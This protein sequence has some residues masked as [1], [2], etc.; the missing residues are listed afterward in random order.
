MAHYYPSQHPFIRKPITTSILNSLLTAL[1]STQ[2]WCKHDC[3]MFRAALCLAF[4]GFLRRGGEFT[5]LARG[6]FNPAIHAT[7]ADV[8][9]STTNLHFHI[10]QSKMDQH[11]F[12][13]TTLWG[14][15]EANCPVRIIQHYLTHY[16]TGP[17]QLLFIR[18]NSNHSPFRIFAMT[19]VYSSSILGSPPKNT[20][21]TAYE[22]E[23]Q[24][25]LQPQGYQSKRSNNLDGGEV[26]HT[27]PTYD[28][29]ET[30]LLLPPSWLSTVPALHEHVIG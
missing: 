8:S 15:Q 26:M 9:L 22:S 4:Y 10:K 21:L 20:T 13:H 6:T 24:L 27:D 3:V 30:S 28:Q 19:F 5:T 23:Q 14:P 12:G 25:Q 7:P 18:C 17:Q 2:W 11:A 16:L 29:W 1:H